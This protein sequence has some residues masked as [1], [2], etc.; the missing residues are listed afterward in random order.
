MKNTIR[1]ATLTL[2]LAISLPAFA[3]EQCNAIPWGEPFAAGEQLEYARTT[4][5]IRYY[6]VTKIDACGISQIENNR[7]IY[8]FRE[9]RLYAVIMEIDRGKQLGRVAGLLIDEHG[10]P[11]TRTE[12]GWDVYRWETDTL[13][14]KLKSQYS[15][16][17]IKVGMYYKPLAP[18]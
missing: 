7:V 15:T 18:K 2:V 6:N 11:D 8:G 10:L 14:I 12:E 17:R 5:G 16:D 9:N 3:Q 13:K 4:N 1:L